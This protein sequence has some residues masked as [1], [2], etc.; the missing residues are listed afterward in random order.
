VT[1]P[2]PLAIVVLALLAEEPM[3]A[4][5]MQQMLTTRRKDQVANIAQRNSVYQTIDRLQ[6]AGLVAVRETT[7]DERRP[8]RTVYEI[9]DEGEATFGR[10]MAQTL[11]APAREYPIF[12]AALAEV[13]LLA[14]EQVCDAM[15]ARA[16][17]LMAALDRIDAELATAVHL[18]RVL[19]LENEF[20]RATTA[21]ELAWI[22][23][24][25]D[26]LRAGRLTWSQEQLRELAAET[27]PAL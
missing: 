10:W 5:R 7:R 16:V 24:L 12:P 17:A 27:N 15:E 11:S 2:S 14:P 18:P 19:V 20:H 9:T 26:D 3:H 22:R 8:E 21:A 6:R 25:I 1:R 4:Y 13:A 23:A